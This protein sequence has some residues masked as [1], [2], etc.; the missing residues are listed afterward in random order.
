MQDA[1]TESAA[2]GEMQGILWLA[3]YPKSGNT[4]TRNFLHNLLDILEG[5]DEGDTHDINRMNELTFWEIAAKPYE[6]ILEKPVKE[7]TR[8]EIAKTRPK[9]QELVAKS[10]DGL[11]LV[12]THHC[13]LI[14]RGVPTINFAVTSGAVYIVRNPLDVAISLANHISKSIDEA[15]DMM[16]SRDLE[17]AMGENNVYEMY[18]SWS[19]HVESWT[20]KPHR[21]IYVM[22]Y[23]DMLEDPM[24]IFGALAQH[25]LLKPRSDQLRLAIERSSFDK[26]KEQEDEG[27]FREKPD[28][29]ERFFRSG[30]S[31]E[32]RERLTRRQVREIVATH[33]KQMSRF[34][35]LTDELKHLVPEA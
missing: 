16:A 26:L 19:Q 29:A 28:K 14:N 4:W 33:H 23:E 31:G 20:H 9:V 7:C 5:K 11:A 24:R 15:I 3:S 35:Y 21:G 10:T 18:G 2:L 27:G 13:L 32:W 34:G 25:L 30:K 8:E 12:K 1:D 22:R 17:T 6:R